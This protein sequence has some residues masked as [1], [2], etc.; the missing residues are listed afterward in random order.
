[1]KCTSRKFTFNS[2]G[3]LLCWMAP[4]PL[5]LA[6]YLTGLLGCE[7]HN[8]NPLIRLHRKPIFIRIF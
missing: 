6:S 2:L 4:I 1:M 3:L 7:Y 8:V 5:I